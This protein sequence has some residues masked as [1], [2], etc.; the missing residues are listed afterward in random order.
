VS[1][2]EEIAT[3]HPRRGIK[4][5]GAE[6]TDLE[7]WGWFSCL[8]VITLGTRHLTLVSSFAIWQY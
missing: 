1:D 2:W 5:C 3:Q 8:G 4:G 7:T 6:W